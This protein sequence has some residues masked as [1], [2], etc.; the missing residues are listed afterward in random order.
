MY[1]ALKREASEQFSCS[2]YLLS[3]VICPELEIWSLE[4][5]HLWIGRLVIGRLVN[6]CLGL[7][8]S[9]SEILEFVIWSLEFGIWVLTTGYL[10]SPGIP[11][12]IEGFWL[13]STL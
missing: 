12:G 11:L 1:L 8:K 10:L 7:W 3:G 4:S 5:C 6:W 9:S 2:G 13:L